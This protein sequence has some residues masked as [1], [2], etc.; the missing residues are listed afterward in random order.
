[1]KAQASDLVSSQFV[2]GVS[3]T[4]CGKLL[5]APGGLELEELWERERAFL[6]HGTGVPDER[7]WWVWEIICEECAQ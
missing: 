2:D 5:V 3:C 1:M 6:E 7:C 4:D